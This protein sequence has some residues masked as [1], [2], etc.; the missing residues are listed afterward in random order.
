MPKDGTKLLQPTM[1]HNY[2]SQL[3]NQ[4]VIWQRVILQS[5]STLAPGWKPLT[6]EH[7][8]RYARSLVFTLIVFE[9]VSITK[10]RS[11]STVYQLLL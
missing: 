9:P 1:A 11:P 10:L 6:P 4:P 2:G 7:A 3:S 5:S 8:S